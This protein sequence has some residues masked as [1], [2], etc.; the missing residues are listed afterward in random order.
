LQ[1]RQ[2]AARD[3]EAAAALHRDG[4][5]PRPSEGAGELGEDR[6]VG[7]EPDPLDPSDA[8]R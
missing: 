5:A 1:D 4:H 3:R 2:A 7:V 8:E 6:E